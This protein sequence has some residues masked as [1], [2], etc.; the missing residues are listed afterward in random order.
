[1]LI[2]VDTVVSHVPGQGRKPTFL[3]TPQR[4]EFVPEVVGVPSILEAVFTQALRHA[5]PDGIIPSLTTHIGS[6]I[7]TYSHTE[8][9]LNSGFQGTPV[10]ERTYQIGGTLPLD[11]HISR[12]NPQLTESFKASTVESGIVRYKGVTVELAPVELS[13]FA[14][15]GEPRLCRIDR[16][17][18]DRAIRVVQV[19]VNA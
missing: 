16:D 17:E 14:N 13:R 18:V 3:F 12:D 7:F 6:G 9:A 5:K 8:H 19:V 4:S 1:M 2:H 15:V 11:L 10:A